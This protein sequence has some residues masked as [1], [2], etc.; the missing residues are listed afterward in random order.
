MTSCYRWLSASFMAVMVCSIILFACHNGETKEK[1]RAQSLKSG[2]SKTLMRTYPMGR[3]SISVP[4]DF[5]RISQSHRFRAC[6]IDEFIWPQNTDHEQARLRIWNTRLAE[7]NKLRKP[8]GVSKIIIEEKAT[9]KAGQWIKSVYYYGN[10]AADDEGYWDLLIDAGPV[11]VLFKFDG[12]LE[13]KDELFNW[14]LSIAKAYRTYPPNNPSGLPPGNW[15][16]TKYGAINLP[17]FEQEKTEARFYHRPLDMRLEIE[18]N[19]THTV[20][21][22]DEGLI[23]RTTAVIATG[24]AGGVEIERIRSRKR[25]VAGL[26]G[27]EEIDRMTDKDGTELDFGWRYAG[28]KGSGEH[29]EILITIDTPDGNLDEKLQIWDAILDS[30]KPMYKTGK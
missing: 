29:P 24:Y 21:A 17:F 25:M 12:L 13:G 6:T 26:S 19:E 14:V 28:Q 22:L 8:R 1:Q 7:I 3:F 15:F 5:E 18:M 10:Y 16:H 9:P 20:E 4:V 11:G 2:G 23:G 27:E 30:F